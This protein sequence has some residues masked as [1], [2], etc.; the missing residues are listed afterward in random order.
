ME[1][2]NLNKSDQAHREQ[3]SRLEKPTKVVASGIQSA[4]ERYREVTETAAPLVDALAPGSSSIS[5]ESLVVKLRES[6]DGLRAYVPDLAGTW[7]TH[8][9][10]LAKALYPRQD[11]KPFMDGHVEGMDDDEYAALEEQVGETMKPILNRLDYYVK[12]FLVG[13]LFK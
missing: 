2:E 9:L 7:A 6:A 5:H 11:M 1:V 12:Y 4:K 10:S 8:V 13:I 3:I